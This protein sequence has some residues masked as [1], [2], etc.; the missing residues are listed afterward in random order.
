MGEEKAR[1]ATPPTA[2]AAPATARLLDLSPLTRYAIGSAKSGPV[3]P[4]AAEEQLRS[5]HGM[6]GLAQ[7]RPAAAAAL[8]PRASSW[9]RAAA[10]T[11]QCCSA[12]GT[13]ICQPPPAPKRPLSAGRHAVLLGRTGAKQVQNRMP[14][15]IFTHSALVLPPIVLSCSAADFRARRELSSSEAPV[16]TAGG[17]SVWPLTSELSRPRS[18]PGVGQAE[19]H[20]RSRSE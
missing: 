14:T 20:P 3:L 12:S 10:G 9:S 4:A 13:N 17:L 11:A 2:V 16:A 1:R 6:A 5:G 15:A 18:W 8:T 7:H 19:A